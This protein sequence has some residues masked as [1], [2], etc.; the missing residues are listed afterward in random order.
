MKT[1]LHDAGAN[2]DAAIN[3]RKRFS[4][5]MNRRSTAGCPHFILDRDGVAVVI[6]ST[7]LQLP[8]P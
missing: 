4:K 2:A 6:Y 3:Y 1:K 7:P 8:S 5:I